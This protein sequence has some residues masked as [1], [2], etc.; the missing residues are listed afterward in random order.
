MFWKPVHKEVSAHMTQV[1][2]ED[3][4]SLPLTRPNTDLPDLHVR[5]ISGTAL[6]PLLSQNRGFV[7]QIWDAMSFGPISVSQQA[8]PPQPRLLRAGRVL[9]ALSADG[10]LEATSVHP[11]PQ[12]GSF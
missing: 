8:A 5:F 10:G 9:R 4:V 12:P 7:L 1:R 2:L 11:S 3:T 6:S